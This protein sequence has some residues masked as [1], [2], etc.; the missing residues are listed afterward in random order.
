VIADNARDRFCDF[1]GLPVP[2]VRWRRFAG[3]TLKPAYCCSGCRFAAS[4]LAAEPLEGAAPRTLVKLGLAVFF[5]M[6]VMVF[7][8]ALWTRDLY[9]AELQSAGPLAD[10]LHEVFRYLAFVFCLPVLYLLGGPLVLGVWEALRRAV[11][12]TD[13]LLLLGVS[14]AVAYSLWSVLAGDGQ[15]YFDVATMILVFVTLGRWLEAE[16]KLRSTGALD[17]LA[18]LLPDSV[19]V[20]RDDTV[21]DV[22][23][24]SVAVGDVL[25]VLPGE[26]LAIDGI[27]REGR[28]EID[29]QTLTGESRPATREPGDGVYSGTLNIDGDFKV[30]VTAAAGAETVSRMLD[31][32]RTSR[33]AKG[34]HQRL[35]DRIAAWFVPI[36]AAVAIAAA[37]WHGA[38]HGLDAGIL[39][40]LAVTLIACPCALGLA[41]PMAVWIALG[42]SARSQVLF[43]NGQA[44]EQ[45]AKV[46]TILFDKTGT[47]TT[48]QA[49][50]TQFVPDDP[51]DSDQALA[52]AGQLASASG[53]HFAAAIRQ[54][55][56][57]FRRKGREQD[58]DHGNGREV[59]LGKRDLL[60][61][62]RT[63][64]GK[65]IDGRF[66]YAGEPMH[67]GVRVLLGS[68]RWLG[69][70]G[71]RM[72]ETLRRAIEAAG[73]ADSAVSCVG[74]SGHIRGA[75]LFR[76]AHRPEAPAAL[77]QCHRLGLHALVVTGDRRSHAEALVEVFNVPVLAEQLPEDKVAAVADARRRFGPVAMVGDGI[78][79]APALAAS[80]VGI[81]L[82]C[83]ADLSRESAAV[84][85]LSD[86]LGRLP[87]TIQLAR[88]TIRVIRQ[89]LCWAFSYNVVGIGL[90]ATGR[91]SPVFS[92]LAMVAS[93]AFVISNSLR[94]G[95]FPDLTDGPAN[96]MPR[97]PGDET[98][99]RGVELSPVTN[100]RCPSGR[101]LVLAP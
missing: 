40:A 1:C 91:L 99:P 62:V 11:V 51:S 22:P 60:D 26:R 98:A 86:D 5:A 56:G 71:L 61:D 93:S 87:W 17:A 10:A 100:E 52:V 74:W 36:V 2:R 46:R 78:N 82:G 31:L 53:H 90:A 72:S 65:G 84:C 32:V 59:S 58:V 13:L 30:V 6:N 16:G 44:I 34:R 45:L 64:A 92:A 95:R 63:V 81:A 55:V 20:V 89:N 4:I 28:G 3:D 57:P 21:V 24:R 66:R 37:W 67:L 35:A 41:T 18:R 39:T 97:E 101:E 9:G 50:V 85:L 94:L 43:R 8:M 27:I 70:S 14:A 73:G 69:E 80:D 12:T 77:D 54:F 19:H 49:A 68:A 79:D 88:Q 15:I 23:R 76:E 25:R 29:E 42:R 47:L 38:R 96:P 48:G 83:G 33:R 7:S 75:F